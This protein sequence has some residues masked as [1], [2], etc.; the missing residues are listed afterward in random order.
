MNV[1]VLLCD[2]MS[3]QHIFRNTIDFHFIRDQVL[4]KKLD[5]RYYRTEDQL[6]YL[7]TKPLRTARFV[8]LRTKLMLL[9]IP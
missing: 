4:K 1:P 7:L 3:A 8:S 9:P 2:S 6:A 5:I